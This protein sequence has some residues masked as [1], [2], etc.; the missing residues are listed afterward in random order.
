MIVKEEVIDRLKGELLLPPGLVIEFKC[1]AGNPH[2]TF[3]MIWEKLEHFEFPNKWVVDIAA[4]SINDCKVYDLEK[5]S[6]EDVIKELL[7]TIDRKIN[8]LGLFK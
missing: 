8:N 5:H 1:D 7:K 3:K 2:G 6:L 4:G